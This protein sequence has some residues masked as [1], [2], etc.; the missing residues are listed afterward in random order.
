M[1]DRPW[2]PV[3]REIPPDE[4][5]MRREIR[6]FLLN[7]TTAVSSRSMAAKLASLPVDVREAVAAILLRDIR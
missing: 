3:R 6:A 2:P 7:Y 4:K 1:I 5:Q